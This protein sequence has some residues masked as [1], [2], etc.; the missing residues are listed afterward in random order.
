LL[1]HEAP[2]AELRALSSRRAALLLLLLLLLLLGAPPED[3]GDRGRGAPSGPRGASSGARHSSSTSAGSMACHCS[4]R[5][6]T[7]HA[8]AA[9]GRR[10]VG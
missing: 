3:G 8:H 6:V 4:A 1:R 5:C 10:A 2:L 9:S 7:Y